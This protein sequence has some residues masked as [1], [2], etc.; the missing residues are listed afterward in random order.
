L[1]GAYHSLINWLA[2]RETDLADV[3]VIGMSQDDPAITPS[4][5]AGTTWAWHFRRAEGGMESR[6][7]S[8]NRDGAQLAVRPCRI[9]P[10]AMPSA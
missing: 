10:S 5:N 8:S 3:V 6:A 2:E 7:K 9:A 1:I 4:E